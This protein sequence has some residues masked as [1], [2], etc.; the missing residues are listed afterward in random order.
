MRIKKEDVEKIKNAAIE[1]FAKDAE[2]YLFGSR[3]E[4]NKRGGDIDIYIETAVTDNILKRKLK[5]LGM[6][7][8]NLG[9]QKIDI[10]VNNF[11]S[12][13]YIYKVA[14]NEGIRL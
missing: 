10:V 6:L 4:N 7:Q 2:V 3:I 14:R 12:D 13:I 9:E 5:M 1:C 11:I 8:S